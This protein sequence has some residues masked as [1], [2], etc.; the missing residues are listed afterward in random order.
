MGP[1]RYAPLRRGTA[2]TYVVLA[3]Q[4]L[5]RLPQRTVRRLPWRMH[6]EFLLE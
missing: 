3:V 6:R 2:R 4:F 1:E 5:K